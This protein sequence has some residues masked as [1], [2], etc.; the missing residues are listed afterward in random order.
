MKDFWIIEVM[1]WFIIAVAV[2]IF[3]LG[4][5]HAADVGLIWDNNPPE[6]QVRKYNVCWSTY[7]G[8][9]SKFSFVNCSSTTAN[10][11]LVTGVSQLQKWYFRVNASNDT[12]TS[13]WSNFVYLNFVRTP[14]AVKFNKIEIR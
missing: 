10:K 6:D 4:I 5:G 7:S 13:N 11:K 9:T 8:N 2:S 1:S 14:S 3:W 12:M